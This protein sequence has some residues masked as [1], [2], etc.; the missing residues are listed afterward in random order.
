MQGI[1]NVVNGDFSGVVFRDVF[2]D[3]GIYLIL[4]AWVFFLILHEFDVEKLNHICKGQ[5]ERFEKLFGR[6]GL[7][8][9]S[10]KKSLHLG[11]V[12]AEF[13]GCLCNASKGLLFLDGV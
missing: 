1:A 6:E 12:Q 13:F 10:A 8:N 9:R 11:F 7:G 4:L 3:L 5:N 2:N